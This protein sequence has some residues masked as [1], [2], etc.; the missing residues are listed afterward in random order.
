MNNTILSKHGFSLA[1]LVVLMGSF[2]IISS[3][4]GGGGTSGGGT[5][6]GRNSILYSVLNSAPTSSCP[7][8][9]ITV[10][11]GIDTNGNGVLDTSEIT[12]TQYVCNGTN[13]AISLITLSTGSMGCANGGTNVCVGPDVDSNGVPDSIT[14]CQA[15]CNGANEPVAVPGQNQYVL[16]GTLVWLDG[17][18]SF[19]PNGDPLTYS[20][21]FVSKPSNTAYFSSSTVVNPD[22]YADALGQYV[23]GLQ[24]DDGVLSS[25]T[26]TMTVTARVPVPDTGQ[27]LS[28]T[29]TFGEDSDYQLHP[30]SFTDNGDGTIKDNVTGLTWQKCSYGQNNDSSCSGTATYVNWYVASGT[31]DATYNPSTTSTCGSLTLA[32]GGWRLPTEYELGTIADFGT[33]S[34]AINS[35]YFPSTVSSDYWSST[36]YAP[37]TANAWYVNFSPGYADFDIKTYTNYVR[38]VRGFSGQ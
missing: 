30:M 7:N 19:D 12:S 10:Y 5:T 24:V 9:G 20:W 33:H 6:T 8:G 11:A 21:L 27:A 2:F 14:S 38:C 34:P 1:I 22:F 15:V 4:G 16:P 3:C 17:S 37:Y 29:S 28:Y 35:V 31:Y 32:G 25:A 18:G 26:K 13:V 36:T 23:I